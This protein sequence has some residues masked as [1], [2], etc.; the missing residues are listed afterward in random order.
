MIDIRR[1]TYG[2]VVAFDIDAVFDADG[3]TGERFREAF[4]CAV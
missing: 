3:D 2:G 1:I 4:V